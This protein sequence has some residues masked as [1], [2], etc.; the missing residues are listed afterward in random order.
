MIIESHHKDMTIL[1]KKGL[2]YDNVGLKWWLH[3]FSPLKIIPHIYHKPTIII[4][5]FHK[6]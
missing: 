1:L 4:N 6:T 5:I 2:D 3:N